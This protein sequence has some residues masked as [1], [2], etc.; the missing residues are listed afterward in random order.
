MKD[1][2]YI[3]I[4]AIFKYSKASWIFKLYSNATEPKVPVS[5]V[6]SW[7]GCRKPFNHLVRIGMDHLVGSHS[8]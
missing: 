2:S 7:L 8:P 4:V 6:C 1:N 3:I 5:K